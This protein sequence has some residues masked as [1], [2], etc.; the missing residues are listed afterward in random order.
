[1]SKTAVI[2]SGKSGNQTANVREI[3]GHHSAQIGGY[4]IVVLREDHAPSRIQHGFCEIWCSYL[5]GASQVLMKCLSSAY[6]G[7]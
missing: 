6:F 2:Q 1:M 3:S 4:R 7:A 5:S